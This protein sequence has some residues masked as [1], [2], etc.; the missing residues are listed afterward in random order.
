M[1]EE[2]PHLYC[3]GSLKSR[4]IAL[5]L[6]APSNNTEDTITLRKEVQIKKREEKE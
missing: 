5:I 2:R 4:H 3:G 1:V 6:T